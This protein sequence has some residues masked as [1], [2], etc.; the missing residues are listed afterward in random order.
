MREG[1]DAPTWE[2][3]AERVSEIRSFLD[4]QSRIRIAVWVRHK[5]GAWF[6]PLHDHH[7]VL[8]V[9]AED[10]ASGDLRALDEGLELPP[11]GNGEPTWLDIFPESE[12]E[13]LRA[14]GTVLWQQTA[15]GADAL[16]YRFTHEP[17]T[18]DPAAAER[19][20]ALLSAEPAIRRVGA[21]VERLWKG[22]DS[23]KKTV[24][25]TIEAA[26][27]SDVLKL[28]HDAARETVVAGASSSGA[29]LGSLPDEA[30]ILY[31]VAG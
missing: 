10:W 26:A 8:G 23:V 1:L 12:V 28:V 6:A 17:F 13:A 2:L 24:Q 25:L 7:L 11:L 14:F 22:D 3:P 29:T 19:F 5:Q 16:D 21:L 30:T 31:E 9:T 4:R 27:G 18:A 20:T 15:P